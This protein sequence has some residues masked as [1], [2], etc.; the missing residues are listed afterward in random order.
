M[1]REYLVNPSCPNTSRIVELY[2]QGRSQRDM[3]LL[4]DRDY[5]KYGPFVSRVLKVARMRGVILESCTSY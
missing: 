3:C 4:L 5:D 1:A 2:Q